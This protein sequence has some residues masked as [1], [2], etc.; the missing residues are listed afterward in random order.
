[1]F[2]V[3]LP[4]EVKVI[5]HHYFGPHCVTLIC[6]SLWILQ[7]N[8]SAFWSGSL[9][10]EAV[11]SVRKC[12]LS[13][14]SPSVKEV[15]LRIKHHESRICLRTL[16]SAHT[17]Q[18]A[19]TTDPETSGCRQSRSTHACLMPST[20]QQNIRCF[21]FDLHRN[22][23]VRNECAQHTSLRCVMFVTNMRIWRLMRLFLALQLAPGWY[24][25]CWKSPFHW[26][27]NSCPV[28]CFSPSEFSFSQKW[29]SYVT[30]VCYVLAIAR[31]ITFQGGVGLDQLT[32]PCP[33]QDLR[34]QGLTVRWPG[35]P[36]PFHLRNCTRDAEKA[37][38]PASKGGVAWRGKSCPFRTKIPR[39][40]ICS[41]SAFL[42]FFSV[43]FL[44]LD[45]NTF[46]LFILVLQWVLCASLSYLS[47]FYVNHF[48]FFGISSGYFAMFLCQ[49]MGNCSF[50][51]NNILL[52]CFA[53]RHMYRLEFCRF[54]ENWQC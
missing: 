54:C 45:S 24:K 44:S 36:R 14:K 50:D 20:S 40:S 51:K 34:G 5:L 21:P 31:G 28:L 49:V 2:P 47:C 48:C 16:L 33:N 37:S 29:T 42:V 15:I 39:A 30:T 22:N 27:S 8:P 3:R 43:L 7:N 13:T 32:R 19:K 17:R 35:H 38:N 52:F 23:Y 53:D 41:K 18:R 11:N 6:P 1:M 4:V 10:N 46:T 9:L 25:I 12:V 26:I